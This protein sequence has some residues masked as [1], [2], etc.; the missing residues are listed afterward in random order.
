[1]HTHTSIHIHIQIIHKHIIDNVYYI[2]RMG[3]PLIPVLRKAKGKGRK[4]KKKLTRKPKPPK[5]KKL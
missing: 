2:S 3:T 1:M 4:K 5:Q